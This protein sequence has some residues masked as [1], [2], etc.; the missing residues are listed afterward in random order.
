LPEWLPAAVRNHVLLLNKL[1]LLVDA[2]PGELAM[3]G[4]LLTDPRMKYA[5]QELLRHKPTDKA[6][7]EVFGCAFDPVSPRLVMTPA[8]R[9]ALAKPWREAA[10]RCRWAKDEFPA[11]IDPEKK[12]VLDMA[13]RLLDE[14]ATREGNTDSPRI[15]KQHIHDDEARDHVRKLSHLVRKLFN[16]PLYGT[17]ATIVSVVLDRKISWQQVRDWTKSLPNPPL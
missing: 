14:I 2:W 7:V 8:D 4:R 5:W 3:L 10:Q 15:V 17:V 12:V 6:L 9:D 13:A 11:S 16:S 1:K